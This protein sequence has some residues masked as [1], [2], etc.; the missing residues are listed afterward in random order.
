MESNESKIKIDF[1]R[2]GSY[3][4]NQPGVP[5][6]DYMLTDSG[7]KE[8]EKIKE[9]IAV[10]KDQTVSFSGNNIRSLTSVVSIADL[11]DP[12]F[13]GIE[14]V[15]EAIDRRR[16]VSDPELLYRFLG[17]FSKF[18]ADIGIPREQKKL[19]RAV[20]EHSDKYK[21]ETGSEMTT[22]KDM[23]EK[24]A[25]IILRYVIALQ[26]WEKVSHKYKNSTMFR[27]V[28]ANEYFY[29]CFRYRITE[30]VLGKEEAEKYMDWYEKEYERNEGLKVTEQSFSI[31]RK[32]SVVDILLKDIYGELSFADDKLFQV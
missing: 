17:N 11:A 25:K 14:D 15:R 23:R 12:N 13:V 2:H 30:I 26:S 6:R 28:C 3:D 31:M 9:R 7:R 4:S 21:K 19:F 16:V 27:L 22:Y 8:V 20:V 5:E 1:V 10:G 32:D 24:V 18:K 29:A